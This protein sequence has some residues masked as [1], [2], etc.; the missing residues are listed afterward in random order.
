MS[1]SHSNPRGFKFKTKFLKAIDCKYCGETFEASRKNEL[2]CS[3]F[4]YKEAHKMNDRKPA[5]RDY[6][7]MEELRFNILWIL[8]RHGLIDDAIR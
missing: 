3:D 1:K 5:P 2:Y 8:K 7:S 4:C 6:G